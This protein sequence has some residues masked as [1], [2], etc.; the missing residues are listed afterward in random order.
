MTY[1]RISWSFSRTNE[2]LEGVAGALGKAGSLGPI[3]SLSSVELEASETG[4]PI[5]REGV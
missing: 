1:S 4:D 3:S 2:A 5:V